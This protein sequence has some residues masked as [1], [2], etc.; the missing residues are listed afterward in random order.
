MAST[1]KFEGAVKKVML[2][3]V[4]AVAYTA[5]KSKG[6][7]DELAK[8]GEETIE[9]GKAL[10]Q[11]LKHNREAKETDDFLD[12]LTAEQMEELKCKILQREADAQRE[13]DTQSEA[14]DI[15]EPDVERKSDGE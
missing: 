7:I 13:T 10:N 4:G 2:A 6:L 8:K 5:E 1:E 15:N 14:D 12:S 11:E 9:T 3:G